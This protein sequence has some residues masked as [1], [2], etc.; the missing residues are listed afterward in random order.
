MRVRFTLSDGREGVG[1]PY[2]GLGLVGLVSKLM[3]GSPKPRIQVATKQPYALGSELVDYE[4][5]DQIKDLLTLKCAKRDCK[6]PTRYA[7]RFVLGQGHGPGF[8]FSRGRTTTVCYDHINE[9]IDDSMKVYS[10]EWSVVRREFPID[11]S[12]EKNLGRIRV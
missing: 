7:V 6:E 12:R 1:T 8:T 5:I 2:F 4:T 10:S 11:G 9:F 3:G